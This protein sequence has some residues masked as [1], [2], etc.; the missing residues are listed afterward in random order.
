MT[1]GKVNTGEEK[2][3][4]GKNMGKEVVREKRTQGTGP[5]D[6]KSRKGLFL[7]TMQNRCREKKAGLGSTKEA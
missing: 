6:Q 4:G 7:L 1:P 5:H 3:P 2:R